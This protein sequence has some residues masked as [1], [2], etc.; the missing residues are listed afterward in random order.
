VADSATDNNKHKDGL[1]LDPRWDDEVFRRLAQDS[2]FFIGI[3]DLQ[4]KVI[5]L[6]TAG[7]RLV[8]LEEERELSGIQVQDF[9]FPEDLEFLTSRFFPEAMR[10]G[11]GEIDVRFR[12]FKTGESAWVTYSVYQLRDATGQALGF[13]TMTRDITSRRQ[14]EESLRESEQRLRLALDAAEQGTWDMDLITKRV[15]VSPRIMEIFGVTESHH[16]ETQSQWRSIIVEEDRVRMQEALEAAAAIDSPYRIDFRVVR[17]VDGRI[18]WV[19]SEGRFRRDADGNPVGIVGVARDIT[20]QKAALE[21]SRAAEDRY[22]AIVEGQAEMLCRFRPDGTILFVNGAYARAR[23]ATAET[24]LGS[25]LWTFV[26]T[27]DE[28]AVRAMIEGLRPESPE[29]RIENRFDTAEGSRW[30]LWTNRALAFDA[31]GRATELQSS[32]IDI[33]D[34]KRAEAALTRSEAEFRGLFELSAAGSAQADPITGR[35]V[36]VNRRFSEITGYSEE[37]LLERT[38]LDLTHPEDRDRDEA[39]SRPVRQGLADRWESEKRYVKPDSTIVW[40]HVVGRLILDAEGRPYRTI[41]SI[42]D[43]TER[44]RADQALRESEARANARADEMQAL[45]E[46]V[47]A[48]VLFAHDPQCL[49]ITGSKAAYAFFRAPEGVNLSKAASRETAVA[50]FSAYRD[51]QPIPF[52]DMP[53]RRAVLGVPVDGEEIEVRFTDGTVRFMFGSAVPLRNEFGE[54]RGAIAAFMDITD[55]KR[56]EQQLQASRERQQLAARAAGLGIFEWTMGDDYAVWEND[57]IY[58]IFGHSRSDGTLT[59]DQFFRSYLHPADVSVIQQALTDG[60]RGGVSFHARCRI[61]RKSDGCV[62]WLEFAANFAHGSDGNPLKIVGVVAD[63]TERKQEEE[64]RRASE[65]RLRLALKGSNAGA[66]AL[67]LQTGQAFWSEEMYPLFGLEPGVSP[68]FELWS[69]ALHPEDRQRILTDHKRYLDSRDTEFRQEFRILHPLYGVRWILDIAHIVRDD[70]GSARAFRGIALDITK[71]HAMEDALRSSEHKFRTLAQAL[72]AMVWICDPDGSALYLNERWI[73][74]TGQTAAEYEGFGWVNV[75]HPEDRRRILDR[76]AHCT[77]TGEINEGEVRYRGDDG[78]YRWHY[79]RGVALR[80]EQGE[81]SAWYGTSLDI[82]DRKRAEVALRESEQRFKV[83]ADTAPAMLWL[84]D[85]SLMRT[86][87]SRGWYEYTD[88][89]GEGG[90]GSGWTQSIHPEDRGRVWGAF[91]AA[92]ARRETIAVDY[93][94]RRADGAYRWAIDTARPRFSEEGEFQGYIG[95][96]I[97]VHE[98]KE[99]EEALQRAND[100][101]EERVQE[102]TRELERRARQLSRLSSELTLTEQRERQRIAQVLHDHLQQLLVAASLRLSI[103]GRNASETQRKA[104]NDVAELLEDAI[105]AS[106]SL[107]VEL[108]PPILHEAGLSA[109]L[110]WLAR[111]MQ[112]KHGLTVRIRADEGATSEPE[113]VRI[114]LFRSARELLFNVVKHAGVDAA[115]LDLQIVEGQ[116]LHVSVSDCGTGFDSGAVFA[117]EARSSSG[118]GLFSIRERLLLLGGRLEMTCPPQGGSCITMIAPM[119]PARS[120]EENESDELISTP[121]DRRAAPDGRRRAKGGR[122]RILLVDDHNV[123]RQGVRAILADQPDME[124]TGEAANGIMAIEQAHILQPDIILMDY[125]MP[126]MNGVDATR[127]ITA[128]LPDVKIIGLSMFEE[129]EQAAAMISAGASAYRTKSGN[130]EG[131]LQAIREV[132]RGDG[133]P[134]ATA[135]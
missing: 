30:T 55:R 77:R 57:R 112:E 17:P 41:A 31:D 113:D 2:P 38:F 107:T 46:T 23:G 81:I 64:A 33:S 133:Q 8:G 54:I 50:Q 82:E 61:R 84:T 39:L 111:W 134:A 85:E 65:E 25:N 5:Y 47:P 92:A 43:V 71:R 27:E 115:A 116:F 86:F 19:Q 11:Q 127:R 100:Q 120:E 95:S 114:L 34:R 109:G 12:H 80:N 110:K 4:F 126:E 67:D 24:L 72:P 96:V 3:S 70:T 119:R 91:V 117:N 88:Q 18:C 36:L 108:A 63:I 103:L 49:F 123:M 75:V 83:M 29:V 105:R 129:H 44:K 79:Y 66:W 10:S 51:N 59:Q 1:S 99:M 98:R 7:R 58:E 125:S 48:I 21:A 102:R 45:M 69:N 37:E 6:N 128:E 106:R 22:R 52:D 104:V 16:L 68:S 56:I 94:L 97:D 121:G 9:F 132:Y 135:P 118:F 122:I 130:M 26:D 131:L 32:G 35:F 62:R 14:A 74:Y 53:L 60:M 78:E 73:Q 42:V 15:Q 93:R 87:L 13:V 101:L 90:L 89:D 76:W 124:V 40:V 20:E 28:P